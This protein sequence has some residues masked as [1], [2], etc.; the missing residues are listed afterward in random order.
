MGDGIRIPSWLLAVVVSVAIVIWAVYYLV[1]IEV[2]VNTKLDALSVQVAKQKDDFDKQI[3]KM[4][5]DPQQSSTQAK[6]ISDLIAKV[7]ELANK[8]DSNNVEINA[9]INA[10]P[11]VGNYDS[12]IAGINAVLAQL[13]AT[14]ETMLKNSSRVATAPDVLKQIAALQDRVQALSDK[15]AAFEAKMA[16]QITNNQVVASGTSGNTGAITVTG[17]SLTNIPATIMGVSSVNETSAM[18][19]FQLTNTSDK[20][21]TNIQIGILLGG[22][23]PFPPMASGYPRL[24]GGVEIWTMQNSNTMST[25]WSNTNSFYNTGMTATSLNPKQP[26]TWYCQYVVKTIPGSDTMQ[27]YNLNPQVSVQSYTVQ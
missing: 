13:S 1:P 4:A 23:S 16:A 2:E 17:F 11:K 24:I 5:S 15:E 10:I 6:S 20:T 21:L 22:G 9:K 3:T 27:Q 14:Q 7:A 8:I 25:F 26:K 19:G 12:Q 18:F